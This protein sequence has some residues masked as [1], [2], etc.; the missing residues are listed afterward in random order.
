MSR[1]RGR[2]R[3]SGRPSE[4]LSIT[5]KLRS[6]RRMHERR[7]GADRDEV[8]GHGGG[9]DGSRGGRGRGLRG[10]FGASVLS[11]ANKE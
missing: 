4:A 8:R 7:R 11:D 10:R 3:G 5:G 6:A 1:A 2:G 9:D